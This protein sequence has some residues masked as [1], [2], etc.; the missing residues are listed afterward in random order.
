M[1][2]HDVSVTPLRPE[3]FRDVLS[4]E[5]LAQFEHTIARG[6]EL[7]DGRTFWNVNSTARGGGVAEMLRSLIGYAR[8]AGID[9]RWVVIGGDPEFF[10]V[11]KRLHNRLHGRRRRRAARRRRARGVR[12]PLARRD[13]ELLAQRVAPGDVVLLHDPQTAG[14]IPR[15]ASQPACRSSGARTSASTCPTTARAR[16][17]AS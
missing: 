2:L 10:R 17:G 1:P 4:P 16:R 9:A 14:M 11:T 15:A 3:R 8:G 5:G 6:R 7:L 12:A 13:A